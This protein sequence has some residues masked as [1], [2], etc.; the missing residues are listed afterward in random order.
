MGFGVEGLALLF[1]L[2]QSRILFISSSS[3]ATFI[4]LLEQLS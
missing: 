3:F 2:V 1:F 4:F